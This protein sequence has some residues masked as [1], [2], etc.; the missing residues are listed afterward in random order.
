MCLHI[1]RVHAH[2][3]NEAFYFPDSPEGMPALEVHTSKLTF[4]FLPLGFETI[5]EGAQ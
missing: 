2:G 3:W 5:G 4:F 1:Q